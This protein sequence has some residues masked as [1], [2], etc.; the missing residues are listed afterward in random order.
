MQQAGFFSDV[1]KRAIAVVA[2]EHVL[3]PVGE[4]EVLEAVV[5]VIADGDGEPSRCV[6]PAFS[7]TS[8]NVP[9]RLFL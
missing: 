9:S 1:R 2:V 5:V 3:A 7:V 4:E 8:V 6:S